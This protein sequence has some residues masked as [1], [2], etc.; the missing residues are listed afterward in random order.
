LH[1]GVQRADD[2]AKNVDGRPT[3]INE[4]SRKILL[5]QDRTTVK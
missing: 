3:V 4:A 1:D 5:G 2:T